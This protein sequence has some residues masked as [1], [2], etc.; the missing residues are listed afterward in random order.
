V[1]D[2]QAAVDLTHPGAGQEGAVSELEKH[3]TH[4]GANAQVVLA[5]V[6]AGAALVWL[7]PIVTPLALALFV[8]LMID[9]IGRD[10]HA[11]AP[12]LGPDASLSSAVVICI[13]AFAV[14]I[15]FLAGH[16]A[17]FVAKLSAYQPRLNAVLALAAKTLHMRLP[18]TVS[19]LLA[20][21]DPTRFVPTVA[22][23][24]QQ[25]IFTGGAVL[26]YVGFLMASRRLFERKLVRLFHQRDERREMLQLFFRVRDALE[27][28]L[29]IQT[30]CGGIIAVGSWALMMAV[31]LEDAFF[32]AFLIFV[33]FYI[34]IVGAAIGII[35]PSLFALLQFPTPWAAVFL[36]LSLFALAFI[37]GNIFLPRM[38]GK[39]LNID[40]VMVLF[41]LAFWG[42]VWGVTGMFLSTPLTLLVMVSLAQFDGTRWIAVLMSA[43]GDPYSVGAGPVRAAPAVRPATET[44]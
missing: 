41:S 8:M 34:P 31:G 10:L 17:G 9:A 18:R 27:R 24:V 39:S 30:L 21:I 14:I 33:I 26:V 2:R 4:V 7:S 32:W 12:W 5:V 19:G 36:S 16:A 11:R 15:F 6:A 23:W 44:A 37:V 20:T 38:Q 35:A 1:G 29:W 3:S 13:L 43:D 40:P 22:T 25:L 28:Y 42:A